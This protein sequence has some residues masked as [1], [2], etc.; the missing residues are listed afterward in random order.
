[1]RNPSPT[2]VDV[3]IVGAGPYGLSSATYL[4]NKGVGVAVFGRPN[5]FRAHHPP[6]RHVSSL[7]LARLSYLRSS[8]QI[9]AR[10][11]QGRRW[12]RIQAAR[13]TPEFCRIRPVVS[14]KGCPGIEALSG[15][16]HRELERSL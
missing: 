6:R 12:R 4:K 1:M 5:E 7:Q 14:A 15:C 3:A 9:D 16:G 10:P 8:Q 13:S 11:L 2:D